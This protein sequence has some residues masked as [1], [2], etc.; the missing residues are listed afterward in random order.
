MRPN[1]LD[2]AFCV[3]DGDMALGGTL[4]NKVA[5]HQCMVQE[6]SNQPR[7]YFCSEHRPLIDTQKHPLRVLS[8]CSGVMVDLLAIMLNGYRVDVYVYVDTSEVALKAAQHFVATHAAQFGGTTFVWLV[9]P[10][11]GVH[12]IRK[13]ESLDNEHSFNCVFG[14]TPCQPFS[15]ANAWRKGFGTEV[16]QLTLRF[17]NIVHLLKMCRPRRYLFVVWENVRAKLHVKRE[18][19]RQLTAIDMKL[20]EIDTKDGWGPAS[21]P[22]WYAVPT[23]VDEA[24]LVPACAPRSIKLINSLA[25]LAKMNTDGRRLKPATDHEG[26]VMTHAPCVLASGSKKACLTVVGGK[27]KSYQGGVDIMLT[28]ELAAFAQHLGDLDLGS[29]KLGFNEKTQLELVG[30]S[31]NAAVMATI[32]RTQDSKVA[33]ATCMSTGWVLAAPA[34]RH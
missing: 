17:F 18:V 9:E 12:P 29:E 11:E 1:K 10:L 25:E 5:C 26:K 13:L 31:M 14:G 34:A 15:L 28:A 8:L 2:C 30:N 4:C 21:R 6:Y 32:L 7:E 19:Q 16:G 20:V 33:K 3:F 27:K 24:R 22:R 23:S